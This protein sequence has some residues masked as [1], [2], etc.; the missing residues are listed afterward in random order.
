MES[1][2]VMGGGEESLL[3]LHLLD[4]LGLGAWSPLPTPLFHKL[5]EI[6]GVKGL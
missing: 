2:G 3:H 4:L 6:R 1:S 5:R